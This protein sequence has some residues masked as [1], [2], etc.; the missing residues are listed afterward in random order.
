MEKSNESLTK[1][2]KF[3]EEISQDARDQLATSLKQI[4]TALEEFQISESE[5]FKSLIADLQRKTQSAIDAAQNA[6]KVRMYE[7]QANFE[8]QT[9]E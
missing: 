6:F 7:E 1:R 8:N 9:D 3:I 2:L 5:K 4:E